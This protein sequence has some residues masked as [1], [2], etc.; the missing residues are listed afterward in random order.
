MS[1]VIIN[2]L[3]FKKIAAKYN[4]L[5]S[6]HIVTSPLGTKYPELFVGECKAKHTESLEMLAESMGF[7]NF[8]HIQ[9]YFKKETKQIANLDNQNN[10]FLSMSEELLS[11]F[12]KNSL[13]NE[14]DMWSNRAII[15]LNVA[16]ALFYHRIKNEK[17][18]SPTSYN[19]ETCFECD[20]LHQYSKQDVVVGGEL[21]KLINSYLCS[22]PGWRANSDDYKKSSTTTEQH[23]YL[24]MQFSNTFY[25]LHKLDYDLTLLSKSIIDEKKPN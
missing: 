25:L 2:E 3:N 17:N 18:F 4:E 19:L 15:L 20:T 14:E 10:F 12:L 5:F 6:V 21:K 22:L 1:N 23:G 13:P 24:Q 9:E 8:H 7:N 16:V 11:S